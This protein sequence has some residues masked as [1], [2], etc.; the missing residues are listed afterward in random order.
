MPQ[1]RALL[2]TLLGELA[3]ILAALRVTSDKE[4]RSSLLDGVARLYGVQ[5]SVVSRTAI[6]LVVV[7]LDSPSAHVRPLPP[8][9]SC[10]P[11]S[12]LHAWYVR[13]AVCPEISA[14]VA[15][16]SLGIGRA[17]SSDYMGDGPVLQEAILRC[18]RVYVIFRACPGNVVTRNPYP[19]S[20]CIGHMTSMASARRQAAGVHGSS[21]FATSVWTILALHAA[22]DSS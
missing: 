1:R 14:A 2:S 8:R 22:T 6:A 13:L 19:F 15:L 9:V 12:D 3:R 21:Q 10:V 7:C 11:L 4:V 20:P 16:C 18:F 5:P 17:Y